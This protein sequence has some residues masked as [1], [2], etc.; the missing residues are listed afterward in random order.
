MG[1]S[2]P[3]AVA[4]DRSGPALRLDCGLL[5]ATGLSAVF[6]R[7]AGAGFAQAGMGSGE[8]V[9][10]WRGLGGAPDCRRKSQVA[11]TD[12]ANCARVLVAAEEFRELGTAR[13]R[14]ARQCCTSGCSELARGFAAGRAFG[15]PSCGT[16]HRL[17]TRPSTALFAWTTFG[18]E[19]QRTLDSS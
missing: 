16:V 7:A 3:G 9:R 15:R 12:P 17:A 14:I 4:D 13:C 11:C 10:G 8:R 2:D 19:R 1:E 5:R 18:G 6:P